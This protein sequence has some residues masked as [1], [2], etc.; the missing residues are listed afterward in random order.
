M[1]ERERKKGDERLKVE[2]QMVQME[3][4][5]NDQHCFSFIGQVQ[6]T[7][8][9]CAF[10]VRETVCMNASAFLC[11]SEGERERENETGSWKTTKTLEMFI[12]PVLN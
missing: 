10:T 7:H 9:W 3:A 12:V 5:E 6:K 11:V 8:I 1:R 4:K 2:A